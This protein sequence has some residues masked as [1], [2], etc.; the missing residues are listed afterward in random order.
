MISLVIILVLIFGVLRGL[1]RG[2]VL[3]LMHFASFIISFVVAVIF[4]RDLAEHLA[5]WIPY[6]DLGDDSLWGIFLHTMPLENAFYNGISF[7]IIFFATKIILQIITS[8]LDFLANL[9]VLRSVNKL[10]GAVLG[11][12]EV[13][14]VTF[15]VLFILALIPVGSIQTH[16]SSSLLAT[17]IV[18][19][20]PFLSDAL[21]SL[22]FTEVLSILAS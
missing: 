12:F 11:F 22:W 17:L 13:Y 5:L 4:F 16:I 1:K 8:M 19:H 21:Q 3:Q 20:T 7:A 14:L 10:L 9:P 15:I 18:E 6:P 2:F